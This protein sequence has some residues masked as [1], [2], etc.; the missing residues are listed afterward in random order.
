M[1]L[2]DLYHKNEDFAM[3]VRL[4]LNVSLI[5]LFLFAAITLN[6]ATDKST[7]DYDAPMNY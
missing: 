6:K 1:N 7:G 2:I 5:L 3:I 4:L